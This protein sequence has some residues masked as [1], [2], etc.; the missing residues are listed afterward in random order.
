MPVMIAVTAH[1]F[2]QQR[3]TILNAGFYAYLPKPVMLDDLIK[4]LTE[5]YQSGRIEYNR[6][7]ASAIVQ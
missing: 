3:D 1:A 6:P 2:Q 5:V 4:T 7:G